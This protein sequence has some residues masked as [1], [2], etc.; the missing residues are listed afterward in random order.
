MGV[1]KLLVS[2]YYWDHHLCGDPFILIQIEI[3]ENGLG[4]SDDIINISILAEH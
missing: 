1:K 2:N 4:A 3:E